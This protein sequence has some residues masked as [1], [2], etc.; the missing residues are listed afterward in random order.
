MQCSF[1][2][3]SEFLYWETLLHFWF[4][5][6]IQN[7]ALFAH[8]SNICWINPQNE[9]L[10]VIVNILQVY[11]TDTSDK[12]LIVFWQLPEKWI[13]ASFYEKDALSMTAT[14]KKDTLS[15]P[16]HIHA[17]QIFLCI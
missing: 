16:C 8:V 17:S 5:T 13:D 3:T 1:T 2:E 4:K 9:Y 12:V 15:K 14:K 10:S 11:L 7:F 6:P